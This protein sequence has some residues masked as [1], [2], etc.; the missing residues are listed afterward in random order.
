MAGRQT[1]PGVPG[2]FPLPNPGA[3]GTVYKANVM[4]PAAA[5]GL[6]AATGLGKAG[7]GVPGAV[8]AGAGVKK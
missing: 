4:H 2:S 1:Q 3:A 6:G 8:A 7:R 5:A